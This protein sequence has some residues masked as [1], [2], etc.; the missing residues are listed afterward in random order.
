MDSVCIGK[1]YPCG[2]CDHQ[3]KYKGDLTRHQQSVHMGKKYPC[4]ECDY[5][6]KK[7]TLKC[8]NFSLTNLA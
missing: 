1:K 8:L 2:E 5:Q 6:A 7:L 4:E 3:A